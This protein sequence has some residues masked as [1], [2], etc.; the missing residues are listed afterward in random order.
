M[1]TFR[2]FLLDI[3]KNLNFCFVDTDA[4]ALGEANFIMRD[5]LRFKAGSERKIAMAG[6]KSAYRRLPASYVFHTAFC[7]STLLC[8]ALHSAPEIVSLKEPN[9]L[10]D[11]SL[12]S[13]MLSKQQLSPYLETVL[14]ELSQPWT[15]HGQ[16]IIKPTNSCNRIVT[17][18][19]RQSPDDRIVFMYSTLEEFLVSCLKKMPQA[20]V[21]LNL[22]ARHL[23]PGSELEKACG[24][25]RDTD[26][27]IIEA[28]VLVWHVSLEYFSRA[29]EMLPAGAWMA[30]RYRD[31]KREPLAVVR[32]VGNHCRLPDRL[33]SGDAVDAKLRADAKSNGKAY[34]SVKYRQTYDAVYAMYGGA[35][36]QGVDWAEDYISRNARI[37]GVF[38]DV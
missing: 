30:V 15:E 35:I 37:S 9:V 4:D 31:L 11:L 10:M 34:D 7:G 3:D 19:C 38:K 27:S 26:F 14:A 17:D 29:I 22:M 28:C 18:I 13:T 1:Q 20:Q 24:I 23:L 12:A 33:L 25:P 6:F 36:K 21:Q 5:G 32:T 16:V 8:R 2:P